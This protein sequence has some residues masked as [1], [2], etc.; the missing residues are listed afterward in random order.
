[1][2][3]IAT[4]PCS[5]P[6]VLATSVCHDS[7]SPARM[8]DRGWVDSMSSR[9]IVRFCD[10]SL[11]DA[12]GSRQPLLT[13]VSP[14]TD[15][16][17]APAHIHLWWL[18][19]DVTT[20]TGNVESGCLSSDEIDRAMRYH[21]EADRIRFISRR[22]FLREALAGYLQKRPSEICFTYSRQG[23]PGLTNAL[24]TRGV[25]FNIS[26]TRDT[27]VFAFTLHNR[28]GIDVEEVRPHA[29]WEEVSIRFFHPNEALDILSRDGLPGRSRAFLHYWTC[30]EAYL[31]ATGLGITHGLNTMDLTSVVRD[32]QTRW[33][34]PDGNDFLV[35][36]LEPD[37][38]LVIGVA[39]ADSVQSVAH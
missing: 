31:K 34:D 28:V 2:Y 5:Q 19:T 25:R 26:N 39:L 14:A 16:T 20:R 27:A 21:F 32:G 17:L 1:M 24:D 36:L 12:F 9:S 13:W 22:T 8:P 23:K 10:V 7:A 30:K 38:S 35:N 11:R 18:T 4:T 3:M 37:A 6:M 15:V 29:D 33:Q